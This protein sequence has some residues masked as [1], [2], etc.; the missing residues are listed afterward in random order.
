[1]RKARRVSFESGSAKAPEAEARKRLTGR[2]ALRHEDDKWA[3][4]ED[5]LQEAEELKGSLPSPVLPTAAEVEAHNMT[6]LPFR[7]WCTACV[8][9]REKSLA[10]RKLDADA[11][12][13]EQV[14]TVSMDYG[15]LGKPDAAGTP[16]TLPVLVVR[17]R[18]SKGIWSHPVPS[19][20]IEHPWPAKALMNDLNNMGYK[21]V[22]LK[23]DQEPSTK[24]LVRAGKNG[25]QGELIPE[26]P[27]KGESKSNGEVELAVQSVHGMAR[28]LKDF[29]EQN[30]GMTIEPR[31]PLLAWLVEHCGA[32]LTLFQ[33]G[34][35]HDGHAAY[36]RLKGKP[37]RVELPGFGECVEYRKRTRHKLESRWAR[38][39]FAGAKLSTTE[40]VVADDKGTY[41]VQS[42]RRVRSSATTCSKACKE[43]HGNQHQAN[44]V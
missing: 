24:A 32:L 19:K 28:T 12:A 37:W 43:L 25:W 44:R 39:V 26:F 35:P 21:R 36:M 14:P 42:V 9:G 15:F 6:H 31:S 30:A 18:R 23:T 8:R 27:P 5:E 3:T 22:T 16:Q 10:H 29:L 17:E 1:M 20:G 34:A 4:E 7:S 41:V 2:N 40:K 38:G 33:K 11:K 13:E